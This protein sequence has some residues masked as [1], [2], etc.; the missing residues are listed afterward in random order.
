MN[1]YEYIISELNKFI[2]EFPKTRVRYEHDYSSE[3]HFIEVVPNEIY[4]LDNQYIQ[5]ES[6]IFDHFVD[7]FP[8]ENICFIS[9]D[10]LVGL[11]KVDFELCGNEFHSIYTTNI[12]EVIIENNQ[13]QVNSIVNK[14]VSLN[15]TIYP[16][17]HHTA[18][19][20]L[21]G[22]TGQSNLYSE[23]PQSSGY[24]LAA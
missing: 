16:E 8:E 21:S 12:P 13:I 18:Y 6:E 15:F 24:P 1:S 17:T 14:G 11:D 23:Y 9:D 3:T 2:L 10:A 19:S 7:I 20:D 4:H 22:I 5:W